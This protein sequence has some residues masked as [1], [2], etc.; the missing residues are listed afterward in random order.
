M[1]AG[2]IIIGK[3]IPTSII[4][5][6]DKVKEC[7]MFGL[8]EATIVFC[9]AL[10]EERLKRH[11]QIEKPKVPQ[12]TID[13][14]RLDTLLEGVNLPKPLKD[15]LYKVKSDAKV[16]YIEQYLMNFQCRQLT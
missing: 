12:R 16:F 11:Y 5:L 1:E 8:Y 9:R 15:N 13:N 2:A 7:Y 3:N 6:F 14:M 4:R 10:I